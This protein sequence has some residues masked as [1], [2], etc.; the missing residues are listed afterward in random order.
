MKLFSL[1][2]LIS[3]FSF[4]QFIQKDSLIQ[5]S[6]QHQQGHWYQIN[7]VF[8]EYDNLVNYQQEEFT[9]INYTFQKITDDS[10]LSINLDT[11]L[12]NY[13][14]V[15]MNLANPDSSFS[16]HLPL[17]ILDSS[18]HNIYIRKN[19]SYIGYLTELWNT[20]FLI[21][22]RKIWGLGNQCDLRIGSDCAE[23][24]I[25][26][27]RRQGFDLQYGGPKGI[28]NYLSEIKESDLKEGDIIHFGY[29]V[30]VFYK[31]VIT[32]GKLD[33]EDLLIYSY[34]PT[35]KIIEFQKTPFF[36]YPYQLMRWK[37]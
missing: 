32:N 2:F 1:F 7:P 27:K 29:Q 36:K 28:M 4:G 16:T 26:G 10:I 17:S 15:K 34:I 13:H 31:D 30:S 25:Y 19:D 33:P 24:A 8:K 11:L 14:F 9:P 3:S 20:P 23:F 18:I 21:P 35:P 5:F 37:F 12:G 22:P 6:D